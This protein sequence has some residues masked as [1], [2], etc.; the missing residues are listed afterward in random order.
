MGTEPQHAGIGAWLTGRSSRPFGARPA[1]AVHGGS[2]NRCVRW[3][4]QGG[5]AFVKLAPAA[6]LP[7]YEAEAEGL[8]TLRTAKALRVPEVIA[9]GIAG[10]H[11][12][13][14]LEW[15]D[16]SPRVADQAAVQTLLGER[17][18]TQHRV[19]AARFG[20]HRPNTIGSTPQP[21]D[22]DDDWVRFFQRHRLGYMLE[23]AAARGLAPRTLERGREL[24][25]RC[26]AFFPG[27]RPAPSLLHGDL[28][29]GNWSAVA[30]TREPAIFDPAVYHGDREADLAFTHLFGGFGSAFYAAYEAQWPLDPG[31]D[32]RR[33]LYNLYHVLNHYVLFG[34]PY[35]RQADSMIGWL[36][37]ELG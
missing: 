37:A 6:T 7:T 30:T 18:A 20:W 28:W 25:E 4:G 21:N 3:P 13:L 33:P 16:L 23:L 10:T 29:G 19:T 34:G 14:A 9:V 15:L 5:D 17:L 8:E 27:H 22:P 26:K 32:A 24:N 35:A 1:E 2:I 11:A 31:A 36:L 12:V